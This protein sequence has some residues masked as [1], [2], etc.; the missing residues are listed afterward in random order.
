[1]AEGSGRFTETNVE[2]KRTGGN[3]KASRD[4]GT[5]RKEIRRDTSKGKGEK[6]RRNRDEVIR[7]TPE[8]WRHEEQATGET[9]DQEA[10]R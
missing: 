5:P 4:H 9:E 1:M 8:S 7:E 10:G 2:Y 3:R 6:K